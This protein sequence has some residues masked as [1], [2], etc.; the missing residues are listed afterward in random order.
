MVFA[1][2]NRGDGAD[3]VLVRALDPSGPLPAADADPNPFV[4]Y[5]RRLHS[6]HFARTHGLD[7]GTYVALVR[8]L[9]A[10]IATVDGVGFLTTPLSLQSELTTAVGQ[11]GGIWV[12][13]ETRNVSGSHKARHLMGVMI[14]LRVAEATGLLAERPRL[15]ISSCGNAALA[16]AVIARAADWPLSVYIP[17]TADDRVVARLQALGAELNVTPRSEDTVGDPCTQAFRAAV[18]AGAVPFSCQGSDNGLA[19]E[20]GVTLGYELADQLRAASVSLGAVLVQVGGGALGSAVAQGL[21]ESVVSGLRFHTVQ[22]EGAY[23]LA[24]AYER[25][26]RTIT[27][28]G[29]DR[30]RADQLSA[31]FEPEVQD[32]LRTAAQNRSDYMWPWS[33]EPTS[34]AGGILD[35]ETYDW[36]ALTQSMLRTAGWPIVASEAELIEANRVARAHTDIPVDHTGSAGLAGLLSLRRRGLIDDNE[37]VAVLFTGR[38]RREQP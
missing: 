22:T 36:L 35:D 32:A 30:Q 33:S 34:V 17:T 8:D 13:D 4:A 5:R 29:S 12:K 28:E 7:D 23:P 37:P 6:Y 31:R 21:R 26:T 14:Y 20:G 25:L 2:P 10:A 9:D 27:G 19:V 15:A 1:C 24:R 18:A 11:S 3:H 16:A 38:D